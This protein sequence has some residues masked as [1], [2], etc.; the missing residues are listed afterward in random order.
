MTDAW[1]ASIIAVLDGPL[2][3]MRIISLLIDL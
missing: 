2:T 3:V 1:I